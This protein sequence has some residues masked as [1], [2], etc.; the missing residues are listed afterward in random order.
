MVIVTEPLFFGVF[1]LKVHRLLDPSSP[2]S[3]DA[4]SVEVQARPRLSLQAESRNSKTHSN[5]K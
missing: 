4:S 2:A 1:K 5:V 3:G